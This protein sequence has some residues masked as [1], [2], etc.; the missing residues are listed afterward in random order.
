MA[1][2]TF[3]NAFRLINGCPM[4]ESLSLD[5]LK[6]PLPKFPNLKH[7][8]LKG[9]FGSPWLLVFQHLDSSSQLQHLSFQEPEG[10]CW[11][12][13][14][15]VPPWMLTKLRSLKITRCKGRN[16]D[17]RFIE[18]MLGNAEVLKNLT[19]T[20]ESLLMRDNTANTCIAT[21]AFEPLFIPLSG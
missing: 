8:E 6:S 12:E 2:R 14:Q 11:I 19:I 7:L 15:S 13:P 16:C 18:Y 3:V 9:S 21:E 1:N 4:L 5:V 17:L 20:C 10:S